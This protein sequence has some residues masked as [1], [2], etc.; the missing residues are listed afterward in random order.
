M[1]H[2]SNKSVHNTSVGVQNEIFIEMTQTISSLTSLI[3]IAC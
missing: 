2:A 3:L 1:H